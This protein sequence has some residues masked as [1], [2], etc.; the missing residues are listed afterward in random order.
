M[1][2]QREEVVENPDDSDFLKDAERKL[3]K[4]ERNI[5]CNGTKRTEVRNLSGEGEMRSVP[6]FGEFHLRWVCPG[7]ARRWAIERNQ[8]GRSW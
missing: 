8:D 3:E 2:A 1:F 6:G 5:H 4:I 7:A